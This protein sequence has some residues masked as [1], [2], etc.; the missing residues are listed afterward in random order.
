MHRSGSG[1]RRH[2]MADGRTAVRDTLEPGRAVSLRV[3][4]ARFGTNRQ[5]AVP[6]KPR[7]GAD[8]QDY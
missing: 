8:K 7:R 5:T 3:V 2:H 4:H 1:R 6:T